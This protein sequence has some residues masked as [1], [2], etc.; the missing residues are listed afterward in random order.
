MKPIRK[1]T[2]INTHFKETQLPPNHV[3]SRSIQREITSDHI[4]IWTLE[5]PGSRANIITHDFLESLNEELDSLESSGHI[6][7]LVIRALISL[8]SLLLG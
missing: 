7:G 1:R 4:C 3:M 5:Q 8:R 6:R 2:G